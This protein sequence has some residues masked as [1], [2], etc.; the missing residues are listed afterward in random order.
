MGLVYQLGHGGLP[1]PSPENGTRNMTVLDANG[2]HWVSFT[3]CDCC[4]PYSPPNIQQLMRAGWYPATTTD[5]RTCAT[6]NVLDLYRLLNVQANVNALDFIK[7]LI[8][9][10]DA[11]GTTNLPACIFLY[12]ICH[13]SLTCCTRIAMSH[14][15]GWLASGLCCIVSSIQVWAFSFCGSLISLQVHSLYRAGHALTQTST[16]HLVGKIGSTRKL[17]ISYRLHF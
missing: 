10:S 1:C 11:T 14:L 6:F 16:F 17:I 12:R 15:R 4:A 8:N 5:P 9:L 7:T 3:Y 2:I 13:L